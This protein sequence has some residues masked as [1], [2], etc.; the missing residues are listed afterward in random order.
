MLPVLGFLAIAATFVRYVQARDGRLQT[1]K[2]DDLDMLCTLNQQLLEKVQAS[3]DIFEMLSRH[4]YKRR[5]VGPWGW[6]RRLRALA[7]GEHRYAY[8][9]MRTK[10]GPETAALR[11]TDE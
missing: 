11:G 4:G 7:G 5:M 3:P 9:G 2:H 6:A 8:D 1:S 10:R